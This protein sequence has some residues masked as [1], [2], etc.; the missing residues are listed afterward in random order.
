MSKIKNNLQGYS[1]PK[2]FNI[3]EAERCIDYDLQVVDLWL[4]HLQQY[5]QDTNSLFGKNILELGPGSDL[6][7]GLYLLAKGCAQYNACDVNELMKST[8]DSF[9]EKLFAR[10]ARMEGLIS[11]D[12]LRQQLQAMQQG[13]TSQLNYVVRHDFD[14]VAAFGEAS[15]DMVVSQAAFEHFDDIDA[16]IR[17]LSVVCKPEATLVI[18]V[19]LKAHSRWVHDK[20]PN[21]IYRYS[22]AVYN[23]L[24]VSGAPN[25]M[26][27][28]QYKEALERHGWTDVMI[29]PIK[30]LD[31]GVD[32][33][34]GLDQA[35]LDRKNQMDYLSIMICARK[36]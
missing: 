1:T 34:A 9:Y 30:K 25:R 35:F 28:Y 11:N 31:G 15:M 22:N 20:D 26:R 23:L 14:I 16:T 27:P 24:R 2:P 3:S 19:D 13:S 33:Y 7:I 12:W 5:T 4:S 21:S 6:G 17:Q 18:E 10:L 32:S 36:R 8:P 29:T